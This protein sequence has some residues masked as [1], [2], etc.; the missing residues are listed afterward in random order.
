MYTRL[1]CCDNLLNISHQKV[2]KLDEKTL[3][4]W[5]WHVYLAHWTLAKHPLASWRHLDANPT[6]GCSQCLRNNM[7]AICTLSFL[8]ATLY[9]SNILYFRNL[10]KRISCFFLSIYHYFTNLKVVFL[11]FK[12]WSYQINKYTRHLFTK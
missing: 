3:S 1:I 7:N 9:W 11:R 10:I 5:L 4:L 8:Y 6:I 2:F 12:G